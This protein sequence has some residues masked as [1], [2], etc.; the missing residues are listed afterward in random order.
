[1]WI[2]TLFTIPVLLDVQANLPEISPFFA[3]QIFVVLGMYTF[4]SPLKIPT[5][6]HVIAV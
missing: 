5:H 3:A 4:G 1:M 2:P 6:C